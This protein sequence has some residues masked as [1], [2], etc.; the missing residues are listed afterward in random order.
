MPVCTA[1]EIYKRFGGDKAYSEFGEFMV[2]NDIE[3]E[4]FTWTY[5]K[6]G[7]AGWRIRT[8]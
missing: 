2:D 5:K 1:K 6:S 7:R 8:G 3:Y 4:A